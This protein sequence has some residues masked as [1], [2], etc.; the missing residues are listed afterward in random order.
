[1]FVRALVAERVW[2]LGIWVDF[3]EVAIEVWYGRSW[4][5]FG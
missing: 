5:C 4:V 3:G 1:M 2:V